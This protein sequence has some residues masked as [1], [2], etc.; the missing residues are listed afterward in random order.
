M[1]VVLLQSGAKADLVRAD[2][3]DLMMVACS[4][5]D[6]PRL[7]ALLAERGAPVDRIRYTF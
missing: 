3:T 6:G 7:V 1:A 4:H 2:G 5:K